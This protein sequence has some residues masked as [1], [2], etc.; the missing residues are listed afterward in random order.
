[1]YSR[2]GGL[3]SA[4]KQRLSSHATSGRDTVLRLLFDARSEGL[5][6]LLLEIEI[7]LPVLLAVST[8]H[9]NNDFLE[10]RLSSLRHTVVS[11]PNRTTF[12]SLMLFR[13]NISDLEQAMLRSSDMVTNYHQACLA[14]LQKQTAKQLRTHDEV[15]ATLTLRTRALAV[16]LDHEVQMVVGSVTVQVRVFKV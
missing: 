13:K 8:W 6:P 12:A 3:F 9:S 16:A 2:L 7:T 1:M 15:F 14:A 4:K 5:M 11:D 10:A